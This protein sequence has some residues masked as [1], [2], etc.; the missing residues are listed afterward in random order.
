MSPSGNRS[1]NGGEGS[2]TAAESTLGDAM[3]APSIKAPE[4]VV[5]DSMP[6]T[7]KQNP[8]NPEEDLWLSS[9]DG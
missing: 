7:E 3:K 6:E 5:L 1:D 4:I 9:A 8:L 2:S